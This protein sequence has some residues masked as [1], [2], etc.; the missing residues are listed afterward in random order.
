MRGQFLIVNDHGPWYDLFLLF[1]RM[2]ILL[3]H[4][5]IYA[6]LDV[7]FLK[8]FDKLRKYNFT[9]GIEYHG[10]PGRL[11][12]GVIV[13]EKGAKFL[14]IWRNTYETFNKAEQDEHACMIPYRLQFKHPILIHVEEKTLNYPSGK[15][16]DLIYNRVYDWKDNYAIHLWHRLHEFEHNPRDIRTMNTTF[17]QLARWIYYGSPK[18]MD[19][20]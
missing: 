4:G 5:G 9:M 7:I 19:S 12:S 18:L 17:G 2:E 1:F 20:D 14:Q 11:N 13:S 8:P 16:L 10:S 6:D 15:Q 3:R